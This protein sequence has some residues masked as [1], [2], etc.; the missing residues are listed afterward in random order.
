[1]PAFKIQEETT[2]SI[3]KYFSRLVIVFGMTLLVAGCAGT[4]GTQT[5]SATAAVNNMAATEGAEEEECLLLKMTGTNI[6][7][8]Y[9]SSKAT[10]IA[11]GKKDRQIA[12]EYTRQMNERSGILEQVVDGGAF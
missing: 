9:C 5:D 11:L 4:S 6:P 12:R 7:K 8:K 2:L 3:Q 10:W 1:M